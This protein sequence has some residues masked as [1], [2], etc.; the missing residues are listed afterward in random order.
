MSS[1]ISSVAVLSASLFVAALIKILAPTGS[2]ENII[3]L[4]ISMFVL[5]C[6]VTCF[7]SV[8]DEIKIHSADSYDS[9][10]IHPEFDESVLK[11]TGD[12]LAEYVNKLLL[13]ED[14]NADRVEVSVIRDETDVINIRDISIY[15]DKSK[16][17]YKSKIE[18]IITS[19]LNIS[20][21]VQIKE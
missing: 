18:D 9:S 20:P 6:I 11:L 4:V 7:K 1:I 12:Y 21:K 14:I 19:A 3:R 17:L 8:A 15:L 16:T 10:T 2:T 5:I 13:A